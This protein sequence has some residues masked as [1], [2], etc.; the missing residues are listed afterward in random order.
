MPKTYS[1]WPISG[2]FNKSG[3][4]GGAMGGIVNGQYML[5]MANWVWNYE[6]DDFLDFVSTGFDQILL[7]MTTKPI[8]LDMGFFIRP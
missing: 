7:A 3:I 8:E 4:W 1:T 5:G 6:R 2:P